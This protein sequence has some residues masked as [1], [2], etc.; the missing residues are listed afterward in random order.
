MY[1]SVPINLCSE[2]GKIVCHALKRSSGR[3]R[4]KNRPDSTGLFETNKK[5]QILLT[6]SL[7]AS[8]IFL[9]TGKSFFHF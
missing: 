7:F 2:A 9:F 1:L 6:Q 8:K 3:R 4:R 5:Y